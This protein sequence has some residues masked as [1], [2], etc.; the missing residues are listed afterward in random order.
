MANKRL[1]HFHWLIVT[2]SF[3]SSARYFWLVV[4]FLL[5][6]PYH[7]SLAVAILPLPK[8]FGSLLPL[9]CCRWLFSAGTLP[10]VL[11]IWYFATKFPPPPVRRFYGDVSTS[12][13]P[14]RYQNNS[15]YFPLTL[16]VAPN[17]LPLPSSSPLTCCQILV[18]ITARLLLLARLCHTTT[19]G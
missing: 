14:C 9:F 3:L 10:L 7:C 18:A 6:P 11:C 19:K 12:P 5:P 13:S 15:T 4:A 16:S 1:A 17:C 8:F 2:A